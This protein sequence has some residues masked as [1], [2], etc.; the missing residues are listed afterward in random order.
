MSACPDR[1]LGF[2][3][4]FCGNRSQQQVVK[5]SLAAGRHNDQVC[6]V[7]RAAA[8]ISLAGSPLSSTRVTAIPSSSGNNIWSRSFCAH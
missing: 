3:Q 7:D 4:D 2:V 8:T 5:Y 6:I 1:A